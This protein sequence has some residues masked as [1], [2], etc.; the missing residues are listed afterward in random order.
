MSVE[1]QET[2]GNS[3]NEY[4][5]HLGVVLDFFHQSTLYLVSIYIMNVQ[6]IFLFNEKA[7]LIM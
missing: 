1:F 5:S 4:D 6:D 3:V 7:T 2:E